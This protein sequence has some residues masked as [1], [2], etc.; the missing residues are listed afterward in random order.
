MG[1]QML[2]VVFLSE[3]E[4]TSIQLLVSELFDYSPFNVKAVIPVVCLFLFIYLKYCNIIL[5]F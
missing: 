4:L 1:S 3:A 2:L 5:A